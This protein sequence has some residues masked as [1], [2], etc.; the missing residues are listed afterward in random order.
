M[1]GVGEGVGA[2]VGLAGAGVGEGGAS[3]SQSVPENPEAQLQ[4][5]GSGMAEKSGTQV[6]PFRHGELR[7]GSVCNIVAAS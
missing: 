6:A 1:G 2:G 5:K 4:V 3:V 7:H